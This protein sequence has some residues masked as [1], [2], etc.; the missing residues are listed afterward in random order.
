MEKLLKPVHSSAEHRNPK[1]RKSYNCSNF[2]IFLLFSIIK[3][4]LTENRGTELSTHLHGL[5][6]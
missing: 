6:K 4:S 5:T 1:T 2:F 3:I